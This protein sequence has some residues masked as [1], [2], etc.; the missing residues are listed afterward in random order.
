MGQWNCFD[1]VIVIVATSEEVLKLLQSD[2]TLARKTMVLQSFRILKLGCILRILRLMKLVQES[3]NHA[4]IHQFNDE[5]A[6]LVCGVFGG[7][8]ARFRL[9][10]A[11]IK[12][13]V[14]MILTS[15]IILAQ[16]P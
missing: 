15:T 8:H 6:I 5:D 2:R 16:C 14:S 10:R 4:G 12:A 3:A 9:W 1:F 13:P 7:D 11:T